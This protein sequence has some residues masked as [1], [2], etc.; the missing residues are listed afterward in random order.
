MRAQSAGLLIDGW[1]PDEAL[2]RLSLAVSRLPMQALPPS[3]AAPPRDRLCVVVADPDP[4]IL[5]SLGTV[6][7]NFDMEVVPAPT[8][9]TL[10]ETIQRNEPNAAVISVSLPEISSGT[11]LAALRREESN[12]PVLLTATTGQENELSRALQSGAGDFALAPC[13]PLEM[14]AR[15]QRLLGV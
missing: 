13:H 7:P 4:T 6:L 5:A 14:L 2:L 12:V 3:P 10:L 15:L 11:L 8:G 1:L 9:G